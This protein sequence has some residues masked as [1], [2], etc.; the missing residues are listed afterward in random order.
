MYE[1]KKQTQ[2]NR[3]LDRS[4]DFYVVKRNKNQAKWRDLLKQFYFILGDSSP[5]D[6]AQGRHAKMLFKLLRNLAFSWS[7]RQKY[8]V[9]FLLE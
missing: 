7:E 2:P 5:F 1:I 8:F 6:Y 4:E 9:D 3:I